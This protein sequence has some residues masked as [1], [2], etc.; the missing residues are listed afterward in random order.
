MSEEAKSM[1]C[2]FIVNPKA[3]EKDKAILMKRMESAFRMGPHNFI[4]AVT[5]KKG[6]AQNFA[7][8][9]A[10]KYGENC[11][12][13][14]CGGDGTVHEIVNGI[15]GTAAKLLVLPLGTGNDFAKKL[16][17]TKK[18]NSKMIMQ[19]FGLFDGKPCFEV[20]PIDVIDVDGH[21]CVNVM[22]FGF[23]TKIE[24]VGRKI[25]AKAPI[26]GANAY[27]VA[28]AACLFTS[29]KYRIHVD[30]DTIS[31]DGAYGKFVEDLDYTLMAVCNG[32][33]YGGG[34]CPAPRSCLTDGILDV[35]YVEA[36]DVPKAI[37]IIPLY[38]KGTAD[39]ST[40]VHT[41]R[42]TG[43]SVSSV[44]G[45]ALNGNCDGENFMDILVN[46]KVLPHALNL[47]VFKN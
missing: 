20:D 45:K 3:G 7:R 34:F 19:R 2:V 21:K 32:S 16:Y 47:C 1:N 22:S 10:E 37:P 14:A 29:M 8:E 31:E 38:S 33:Y 26:L 23:D 40:Y 15:C 9:Y 4:K 11:L 44:D 36:V 13:I 17:G 12:I 5:E 27:N 28:V 30:F 43:G 25:A 6:D 24:T 39:Q 18:P 41:L 35:C 42:V 46:F